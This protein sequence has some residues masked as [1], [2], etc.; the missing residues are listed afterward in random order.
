MNAVASATV[1]PIEGQSWNDLHC[2][3]CGQPWTSDTIRLM[4]IVK[5]V[6]ETA[7]VVNQLN[8]S[9]ISHESCM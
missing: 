8:A 3:G 9:T 2:Y 7:E 4:R 1:A 5:T 6:G